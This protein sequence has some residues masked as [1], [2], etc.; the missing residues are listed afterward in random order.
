MI[1]RQ[2]SIFEYLSSRDGSSCRVEEISARCILSEDNELHLYINDLK[3]Y[4]CNKDYLYLRITLG[5]R[6]YICPLKK[7]LEYHRLNRFLPVAIIQLE[8][9][10][11]KIEKVTLS[12]LLKIDDKELKEVS[13]QIHIEV[14]KRTEPTKV[15]SSQVIV[16]PSPL[17]CEHDWVIEEIFRN[18]RGDIVAVL[19]RCRKCGL[20]IR[21]SA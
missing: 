2:K 6:E 10:V 4:E 20:T 16:V 7:W 13:S 8:P 5:N 11:E 19:K 18:L 17:N 14:I 3:H 15:D 9:S 12:I 1:S 21:E